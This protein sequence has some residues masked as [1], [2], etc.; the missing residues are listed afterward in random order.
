MINSDLVNSSTILETVYYAFQH[1]LK[2]HGSAN[3]GSRYLCER[4]NCEKASLILGSYFSGELKPKLKVFISMGHNWDLTY[5][6]IID[7]HVTSWNPRE[8]KLTRLNKAYILEKYGNTKVEYYS[9]GF[10]HELRTPYITIVIKDEIYDSNDTKLTEVADDN[11][12]EEMVKDG[13]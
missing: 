4:T 7:P 1:Y 11:K 6:R 8:I 12:E 2:N 10:D 13:N 3:P 5:L 9:L